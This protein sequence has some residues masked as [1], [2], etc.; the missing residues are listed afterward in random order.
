MGNTWP[1]W[2]QHVLKELERLNS[3]TEKLADRIRD[4]ETNITILQ[5]KAALLG[6]LGGVGIVIVIEIIKLL[7]KGNQSG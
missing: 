5:T 2:C 1:E 7:L 4:S 3:N 6:S